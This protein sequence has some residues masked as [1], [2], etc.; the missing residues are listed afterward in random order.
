MPGAASEKH[1]RCDGAANAGRSNK[2]FIDVSI[3]K[4]D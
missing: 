1:I 4:R 2:S 3:E